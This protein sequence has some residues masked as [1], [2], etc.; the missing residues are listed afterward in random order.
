MENRWLTRSLIAAILVVA[1]LLGFG[2]VQRWRAARQVAKVQ[3]LQQEL[4]AN[5]QQLPSE[6][7]RAKFDELRQATAGLSDAQRRALAE[8]MRQRREEEMKQYFEMPKAE[9]VK[10]LDQM[11]D[12]QEQ[13]RRQ[14]QQQPGGGGGG[15]PG[16]GGGPGGGRPPSGALGN[17]SGSD[18]RRRSR[19]DQSSPEQRARMDQFRKDLDQRRSQRGLPRT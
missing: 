11:I 18:D 17:G 6:Q 5:G 8:P 13:A 9:K 3:K 15:P 4:F 12:R 19:L 10:F 16:F 7:R 1:C 2:G 14:R